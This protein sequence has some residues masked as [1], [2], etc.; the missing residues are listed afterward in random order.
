M[1]EGRYS[2]NRNTPT[3]KDHSNFL[4]RVEDH[5]SPDYGKEKKCQRCGTKI[6]YMNKKVSKYCHACKI[7][8]LEEADKS[9]NTKDVVKSAYKKI[10]GD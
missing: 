3:R 2:T 8:A 10:E 9:Y 5:G 7:K 4:G 6:N 1:E